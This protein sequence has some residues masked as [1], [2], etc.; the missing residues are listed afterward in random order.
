MKEYFP[1]K[2]H[3]RTEES[4]VRLLQKHGWEG[5]GIYWAIVEKVYQNDGYLEPDF[6]CIAFDL[7]ADEKM[8]KAVIEDFNLFQETKK[9]ISSSEILENLK[10]RKEKSSKAQESAKARWQKG[11]SGVRTQCERNATAIRPQCE[12]NAIKEKKRKGEERKEDKSII[13]KNNSEQV[14]KKSSENLEITGLLDHLKKILTIDDFKESQQWQ[15]RYGL[16]LLNL[17]KKIGKDEFAARLSGLIDDDFKRK[18]LNS[19]KYLY[20]ELKSFS[21]AL[22]HS[23][24]LDLT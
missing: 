22:R 9:G 23:A 12:G 10:I 19:I 3:A 5:Y 8:I 15:R 13:I 7:R 24:I 14:P 21:G 17:G 18:N 6:E 20:G 1:H 16:H 11:G 4:L 2:Y